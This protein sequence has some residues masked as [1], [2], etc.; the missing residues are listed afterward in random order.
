MDF[1][2]SYI[3]VEFF[4]WVLQK[5]ENLLRNDEQSEVLLQIKKSFKNQPFLVA[6]VA[7]IFLSLHYGSTGCGI[8]S[9]GGGGEGGYKIRKIFA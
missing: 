2:Q 4:L 8:F 3:K 1:L 7:K 6:F 9:N 5:V